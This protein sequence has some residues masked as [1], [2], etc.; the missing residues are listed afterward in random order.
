MI[1]RENSFFVTVDSH[2]RGVCQFVHYVRIEN[3]SEK[4][5]VTSSNLQ[6]MYVRQPTLEQVLFK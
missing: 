5:T 6:H 1:F 4:K 2:L 3:E